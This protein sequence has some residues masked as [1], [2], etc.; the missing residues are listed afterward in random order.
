[1][2][3]ERILKAGLM[4]LESL[5]WRRRFYYILRFYL[6]HSTFAKALHLDNR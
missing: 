4:T 1:M 3:N 2:T 5:D 6:L